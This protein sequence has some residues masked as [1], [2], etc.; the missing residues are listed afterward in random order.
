V[1]SLTAGPGARRLLY[2]VAEPTRPAVLRTLEDGCERT[3]LDPNA[4]WL[5]AVALV[6]PEPLLCPRDGLEIPYWLLLPPGEARVP[7]IVEIHGGPNNQFSNT[8]YFDQQLWAAHGYAVVYGNPRGSYGYSLDFYNGCVG[9]LVGEDARDVLAMLDHAAAT[10]PRVDAGVAAVTGYSYGG[11]MT[12]QIVTITDRF[13]AAVS[14]AGITDLV[15]WVATADIGRWFEAKYLGGPPGAR[16]QHYAERS[17]VLQA[18]RVRTPLLIFHGERDTRVP[19]AQAEEL[20]YALLGQGVEAALLRLPGDD[21]G[22]IRR[23]GVGGGS[24]SHQLAVRRA[25]LEWFDRH[26]GMAP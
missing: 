7:A 16:L 10:H 5:N 11:Y 17:P 22:S 24:P 12:N 1:Q 8:F 14:G 19:I 2:T 13:R 20:L 15:S 25:V 26:L 23:V 9:D 21:H 4:D 3:V 6:V 18:D